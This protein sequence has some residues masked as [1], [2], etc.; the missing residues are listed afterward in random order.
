MEQ[1]FR[2][3]QCKASQL[4]GL[5]ILI[6][7]LLAINLIP[8]NSWAWNNRGHALIC[9]AS[10]HLINNVSLRRYLMSKGQAIS[11]LC[12]LPDTYWRNVPGAD[13]G[14]PTHFFEVDIVGLKIEAIPTDSGFNALEKL[15]LGK[16]NLVRQSP[17]QSTE[18]ELG[19]VWWRAEQ[20]AR[21]ATEAGRRAKQKSSINKDDEDLYQMWVMMGLLGH[22]IAD[23]AQPFHTTMN[24]D[25]YQNGHGGIHAYYE[26]DL[27]N[28]QGPE[29]LLAIMNEA[30]NAKR[31]LELSKAYSLLERMKK[32]AILSHKDIEAI[33]KMD[34][35][36]KPSSLHREKGME[37]KT[38][39]IRKPAAAVAKQFKPILVKNLARGAALLAAT[40]EDIFSQAGQPPIDKDHSYRFPHE[41]EFIAP[42]YTAQKKNQ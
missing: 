17:L 31:S 4:K 27:V 10:I 39:A 36:I 7:G 24:Y 26:N 35:I 34:P 5:S 33:L 15:A 30:K 32:L 40:W 3:L 6:L 20:F 13:S 25:G 18:R 12:N 22:F 23:N 8:L 2:T 37:L 19:S 16:T 38:E 14:G 28:E 41:Y 9:E 1:G 42:D 11:Y 21:L 29:M